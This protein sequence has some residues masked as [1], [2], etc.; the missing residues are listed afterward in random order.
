MSETVIIGFEGSANKLGVGIVTSSGKIL[1][2]QRHTFIS[3]PG[4]GFLPKETATH[5][6]KHIFELIEKAFL[7][8]GLKPVDIDAIAYTKGPGIARPLI[9]VALVVRTL[10]QLWRKPIV[11]VNHCV[12]RIFIFA[13][14]L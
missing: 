10:S 14:I 12:A 2:N 9:S 5:H 11:A 7:E 1:A 8:S 6:R 3:P 4:T 13:E